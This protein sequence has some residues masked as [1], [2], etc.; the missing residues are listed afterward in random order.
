MSYVL[1][2]SWKVQDDEKDYYD[3]GHCLIINSYAYGDDN[4]GHEHISDASMDGD[5]DD[6]DDDDDSGIAPAA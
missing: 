3:Q 5:D 6:D 2:M 1:N 4:P